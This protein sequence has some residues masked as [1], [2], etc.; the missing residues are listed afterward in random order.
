MAGIPY[1]HTIAILRS[2]ADSGVFDGLGREVQTAFDVVPGLDAI[3]AWVQG[4]GTAEQ[5]LLS[6][7]GARNVTHRIFLDP[8]DLTEAD[9]IRWAQGRVDFEVVDVTDPD[10]TG[11][12]LEVMCHERIPVPVRPYLS[13]S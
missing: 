11:D 3:P 2:Y 4:L 10:G 13:G 1:P 12:H 5:Q 6:Q 7:A 9:M 8:A